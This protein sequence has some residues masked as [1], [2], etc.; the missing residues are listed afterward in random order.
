MNLLPCESVGWTLA[1]EEAYL[2]RAVFPDTARCD[3][4]YGSYC[5]CRGALLMF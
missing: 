2:P 3:P 1:L 4:K 5:H